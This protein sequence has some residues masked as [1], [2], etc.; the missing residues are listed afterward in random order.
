MTGFDELVGAEPTGAERERLRNV[1][2]LLLQAGPPPELSPELAAGPTLAMTLSRIGRLRR[3]RPRYVLIA[4]AA[5]LA[6]LIIAFSTGLH[7]HGSRYPTIAMRGTSFAS[8]ATGTLEL[9]P[10]KDAR[11]RMRLEVNG[12]P[13]LGQRRYIV[14]LVRNGRPVAPCGSFTVADSR[15]TLTVKLMSPYRLESSDSW[16]VT[17]QPR[18][19]TG[20]GVTVLQPPT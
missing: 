20:P 12:L 11:Q 10:S 3:Q 1:H 17:A 6:A 5:A 16:V 19:G 9:L 15:R 7:G 14:Y 18:N 13:S 8:G 4:A 2:D